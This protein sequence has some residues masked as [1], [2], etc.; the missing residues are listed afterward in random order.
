MHTGVQNT[1][2][3]VSSIFG[4]LLMCRRITDDTK[5]YCGDSLDAGSDDTTIS[6]CNMVCS[7]DITEFCGAGNRVELYVTTS[8]PTATLGPKPTVS[9]FTRLGCY[10]EVPG[11]ALTGANYAD[12]A[13][14]LEMCASN[15]AGFSYFAAE[16]SSECKWSMFACVQ[17]F[18]RPVT[19]CPRN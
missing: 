7:G 4:Y 15:C 10:T 1:A 8:T 16:Y 9:S 5:G 2:V 17:M 14:T 3:N 13:M 18:A 6:E 11:R 19:K 12:S